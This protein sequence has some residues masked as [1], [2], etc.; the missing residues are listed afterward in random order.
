MRK[1]IQI[2]EEY[3]NDIKQALKL[4][5]DCE[6]E[7][8]LAEIRGRHSD[9]TSAINA[10]RHFKYFTFSKRN[11]YPSIINLSMEEINEYINQMEQERISNVNYNKYLT[12]RKQQ[13]NNK[14][15]KLTKLRGI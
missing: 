4:A 13:F 8:D 9:I 12:S 10:L 15:K 1:A 2:L 6:N 14:L 5:V 7:D 3:N 11:D